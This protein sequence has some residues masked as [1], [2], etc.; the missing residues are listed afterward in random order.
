LNSAFAAENS[1][2]VRLMWSSIEP[3]TSSSISTFTLLWR[4]GTIRRSSQPA[5]AAVLRI[6]PGRS[7]SSAAP[8]RAKRRRRRSATLMLRVPIST[9]SS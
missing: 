8:S 9:E 5:F 3:P 2:S 6:V 7:S 4:S 1:S